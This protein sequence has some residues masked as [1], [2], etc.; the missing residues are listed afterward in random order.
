MTTIALQL[1]AAA[2]ASHARYLF[3]KHLSRLRAAQDS[4]EGDDVFHE[5]ERHVDEAY[6]VWRQACEACARVGSK[7]P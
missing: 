5:Y 2:Q 4:G 1:K 6:K 7:T 3:E